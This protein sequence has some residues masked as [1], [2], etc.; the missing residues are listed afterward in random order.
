[1]AI[2]NQ[3]STIST[4]LVWRVNVRTQ[5]CMREPVPESWLRLGG[6]ALIGRILVDEV[7]GTCEPLGPYNKLL[8]C[9]GLPVGRMLSARDRLSIGSKTPPTRGATKANAAGTTALP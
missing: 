5:T 6:R 8:F 4:P 9:P 7:P 1:M 3:Q 2:S